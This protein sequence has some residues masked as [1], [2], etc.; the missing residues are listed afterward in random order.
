MK[1]SRVSDIRGLAHA[2]AGVADPQP[3]TDGWRAELVD[4]IR[5]VEELL[6]DLGLDPVTAPYPI[7][8]APSFPFLATRSFASRMG[9][10]D[11]Y[12][13]LLLQV[14][15]RA[16]ENARHDDF[17]DDA[18]G[19]VAAMVAPG[20]LHKY[21]GR[22]LMLASPSCATNCRFC[23]RKALRCPDLPRTDI[24]WKPVWDY[25]RDHADVR[26]LILS[27]G[28]PLMLDNCH[29]SRIM[30]T[31]DTIPHVRALRIHT[32]LPVTLP[33]RIDEELTRLLCSAA[34]R[35]TVTIMIHANHER[36][37][38]TDCSDA[39]RR[40]KDTGALLLH[41]GVLL[42]GINNTA[43]AL[44]QLLLSLVAHGVLPCYLHQLDRV[45]GAA[46]FEVTEGEGLSLMEE[47]RGRLPG[48]ALP[49]YVREVAG[50]RGKQSL[51][52]PAGIT[53]DIGISGT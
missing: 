30:H 45:T 4:S 37:L 27:G 13:P 17:V 28:D 49:R 1:S 10:G 18:V 11:W 46:H 38:R 9:K 39:L 52:C 22:A 29:I 47:L 34:A 19:D 42:K 32:R 24:D 51:G 35:M 16:E 3:S 5:S 40:L 43:D 12:D 8:N 25:L 15:P 48:Y 26:E 50:A 20:L 44:E 36:E 53:P 14:L 2:T 7:L 23:F 33:S 6:G 41:Q 31:V 21:H